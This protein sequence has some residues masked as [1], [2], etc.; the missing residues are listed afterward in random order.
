[1][2]AFIFLVLMTPSSGGGIWDISPMPN[3]DVCIK[4]LRVLEARGGRGFGSN[5]GECIEIKTSE[6]LNSAMETLTGGG[7]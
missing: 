4:M 5:I 1:M 2:H 6:P 3:T 7:K